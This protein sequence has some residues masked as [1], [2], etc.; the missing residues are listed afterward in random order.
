[1]GFKVDFE[2][3]HNNIWLSIST[4]MGLELKM[5]PT[6]KTETAEVYSDIFK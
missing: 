1:M 6:L 2:P 3:E 5:V 4:V